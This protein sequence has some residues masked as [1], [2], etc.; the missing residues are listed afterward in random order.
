[1]AFK[2]SSYSNGGM[3]VDWLECLLKQEIDPKKF[4]SG[5]KFPCSMIFTAGDARAVGL[6]VGHSPIKGN[7]CHV[8][9]WNIVGN[10]AVKF[11]SAQSAAL[12]SSANWYV[13]PPKGFKV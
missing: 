1:M 8:D 5:P 9:I 10:R 11:T 6:S 7:E 4:V 2:A 3:S 12:V 13:V